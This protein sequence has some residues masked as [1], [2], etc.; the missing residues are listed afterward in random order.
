VIRKTLIATLAIMAG[1]ITYGLIAGYRELLRR[2][3][4]GFHR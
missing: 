1:F 4:A 2:E 3:A